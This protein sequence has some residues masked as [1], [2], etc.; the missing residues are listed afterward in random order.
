[1]AY[2]RSSMVAAFLI[3]CALPAADA[4]V[5]GFVNITNND[6]LN[7]AAGEAQLSVAVTD[8]GGG[9]VLFTFS[10]T[11]SAGFTRLTRAS[12]RR[13]VQTSAV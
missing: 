1:M 12:R 3:L 5:F 4:D 2:R 9:Q 11:G 10:N 6:P 8:S 7:A 13:V